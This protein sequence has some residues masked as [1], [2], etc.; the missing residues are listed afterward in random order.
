MRGAKIYAKKTCNTCH[1]IDGSKSTG[2]SWKGMWGKTEKLTST[3]SAPTRTV[4]ENYVRDSI[5]T[6]QKDIVVDD[7]GKAYPPTMPPQLITDQKDID[8]VIA[9]LKSLAK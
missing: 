3:S 6:P 9:Y 7:S 8:A 4:D 1:S 5:L 2:P